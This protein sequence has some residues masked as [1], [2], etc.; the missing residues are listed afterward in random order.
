MSEWLTGWMNGGRRALRVGLT[1]ITAD[2]PIGRSENERPISKNV[3]YNT[4]LNSAKKDDI[5]PQ[6]KVL[7]YDIS[8]LISTVQNF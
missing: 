2:L 3:E 6:R 8:T 1:G 4:L 7:D 5:I